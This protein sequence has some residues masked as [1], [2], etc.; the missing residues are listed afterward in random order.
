MRKE[1]LD[2]V[3]CHVSKT[4]TPLEQLQMELIPPNG[5][6]THLINAEMEVDGKMTVKL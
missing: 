3:E 1:Q 5:N 6:W 4:P 2:S